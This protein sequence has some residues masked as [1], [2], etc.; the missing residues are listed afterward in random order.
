MQRRHKIRQPTEG[1]RDCVKLHLLQRWVSTGRHI[2]HV[3]G[4][5]KTQ[6]Q[7]LNIAFLL[8]SKMGFPEVGNKVINVDET[9]K[10]KKLAQELSFAGRV[11]GLFNNLP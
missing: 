1:G 3:I 11:Y 8:H 5:P 2:C 4:S 6:R 10:L 9:V 7:G